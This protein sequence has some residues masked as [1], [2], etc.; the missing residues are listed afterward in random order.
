MRLPRMLPVSSIDPVRGNPPTEQNMS[1]I[2]I[3]EILDALDHGRQRATYGAVAALLGT[4]PRTLMAGRERD[5]R[6]SWVVSRKNGEPTGYS[7]EQMH[8]NLRERPEIFQTKEDL[9]H[10]LAARVN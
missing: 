5:Q 10:F 7:A 4:S 3:D 2:T 8:P 1:D 9:S 6:H